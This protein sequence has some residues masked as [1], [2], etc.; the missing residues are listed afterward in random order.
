[1][2]LTC[3]CVVV[4]SPCFYLLFPTRRSF[5]I[6]IW[7]L[8]TLREPD[9]LEQEGDTQGGPI[10]NRILTLLEGGRRLQLDA[11]EPNVPAWAPHIYESCVRENPGERPTFASLLTQIEGVVEESRF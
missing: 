6:V 7:E 2:Q 4:F 9:L 8:A 3:V 1:V 5:G 11:D 10:T